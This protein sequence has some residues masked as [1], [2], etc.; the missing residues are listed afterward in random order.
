MC[1]DWKS[2]FRLLKWQ[3]W[4]IKVF[5]SYLALRSVTSKYFTE[6]FLKNPFFASRNSSL[7][8]DFAQQLL[9]H[10]TEA[11]PLELNFWTCLCDL[12]MSSWINGGTWMKCKLNF[13]WGL[14]LSQFVEFDWN[15]SESIHASCSCWYRQQQ[16]K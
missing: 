16:N 15:F 9:M 2:F 1:G 4:E 12:S 3:S 11:N 5:F 7:Q 8:N 14:A 6:K 10:C 13:R